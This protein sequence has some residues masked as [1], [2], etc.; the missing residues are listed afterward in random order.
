MVLEC[1]TL[2]VH[3]GDPVALRAKDDEVPVPQQDRL[4]V[5]RQDPRAAKGH[6]RR[7]ALVPVRG[8]VAAAIRVPEEAWPPQNT[9]LNALLDAELLRQPVERRDPPR[10]QAVPRLLR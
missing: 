7:P 2:K 4:P 9:I 8:G 10:L 1:G 5:D 3:P 6:E